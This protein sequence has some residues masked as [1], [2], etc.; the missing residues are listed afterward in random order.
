M[1]TLNFAVKGFIKSG[2]KA[3]S[4]ASPVLS[5]T[6]SYNGFKLN[7]KAMAQLGVVAGVDK[8]HP[9]DRVILFDMR[10][11]ENGER[12]GLEQ[13]EGFFICKAGFE[14]EKGVEQGATI[15]SHRTFNYSEAYGN[16]LCDDIN[17]ESIDYDSLV[18]KGLMR[19]T[20]KKSKVAMKTVV[21]ELIPYNDGEPTLIPGGHER[22]LFQLGNFRFK[23]NEAKD[24]DVTTE[25][26]GD[27]NE[28]TTQ[29]VELG[30]E[31]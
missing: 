4:E 21:T 7:K 17:V 28:N 16:I 24:E 26:A 13:R 6:T 29:T 15:G 5:L 31:E 12:T 8:E 1:K 22:V 23:D 3:V 9:G 11:D 10:Y 25:P 14:D 30:V 20:D 2:T 27:P 19:T 18:A